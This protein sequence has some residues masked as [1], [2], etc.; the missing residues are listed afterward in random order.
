MYL[1]G[2]CN[3]VVPEPKPDSFT[4]GYTPLY[5]EDTASQVIH[6]LIGSAASLMPDLPNDSSIKVCYNLIIFLCGCRWFP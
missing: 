4:Y 6:P 1:A 3:G 2:P 5:S